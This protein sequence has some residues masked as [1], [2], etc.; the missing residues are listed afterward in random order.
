MSSMDLENAPDQPPHDT[1]TAPRPV[2]RKGGRVPQGLDE[3][4]IRRVVYRF[5]DQARD[6]EVIGPVFRSHVPDERWDAHL[7]T[8]VDFWS[9][10]L[11]GTGRYDGRPLPKHLAI[12]ELEDR[13]FRRWLA[14][15][16]RTAE[17]LCPPDVAALFVE[18]SE[19]IAASFRIN[20]K[21]ARGEDLVQVKPLDRE[22]LPT[23]GSGRPPAPRS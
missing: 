3:A 14:L 1:G 20:I 17:E 7:D 10:S 11:L 5:Y 13:H 9:S 23:E 2:P 12:S 6:D 15:F 22:T 4:L 8:I 16:R 19:R 18:R 21:M